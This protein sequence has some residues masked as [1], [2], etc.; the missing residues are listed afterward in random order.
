MGGACQGFLGVTGASADDGGDSE[1]ERYWIA[2]YLCLLLMVRGRRL[3]TMW[4]E[5][6]VEPWH[7][8]PA[9]RDVSHMVRTAPSY[10]A[11][12]YRLKDASMANLVLAI[13]YR[14]HHLF[15]SRC[16]CEKEV[17]VETEEDSASAAANDVP[18]A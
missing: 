9:T 16:C 4:E 11:T 7:Y 15:H 1:Q 3:P 6:D 14:H 18:G 13:H 5:E 8:V 10:L 17:V 12:V 2:P